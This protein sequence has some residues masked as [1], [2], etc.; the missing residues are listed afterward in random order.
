VESPSSK[1]NYFGRWLGRQIG[2]VRKAIHTPVP[3]REIF[4]RNHVQEQTHPANPN[5][6]LRRVV[7]DELI[8]KKEYTE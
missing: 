1:S 7:T 2:Y 4:R 3:A 5:I 6:T 8:V